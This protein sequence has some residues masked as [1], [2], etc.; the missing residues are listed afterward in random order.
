MKRHCEVC[1]IEADDY[2]MQSYNTGRRTVWLCWECY[3]TSQREATQSD[4][5]RQQRL[6]RIH[7][8]NKRK[9]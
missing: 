5:H 6:Y 9:R 7:E 8:S 3:Q 4:L 1:G 2:W